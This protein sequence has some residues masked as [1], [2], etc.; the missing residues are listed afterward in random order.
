MKFAIFRIE[1]LEGNHIINNEMESEIGIDVH[2]VRVENYAD[3]EQFRVVLCPLLE[4][5]MKSFEEK[6]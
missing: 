1:Q 4:G 3:S 2:M 6:N 5:E